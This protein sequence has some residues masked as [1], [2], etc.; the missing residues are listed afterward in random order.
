MLKFQELA[1]FTVKIGGSEF[2]M[3]RRSTALMLQIGDVRKVFGLLSPGKGKENTAEQA[4]EA[5]IQYADIVSKTVQV[6]LVDIDGQPLD[7]MGLL[8]GELDHVGDPLFKAFMASGLDADP[9]DGSLK[10]QKEPS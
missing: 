4:A 3:R 7:G 9:I 2:K 5:A 6:A 8:A 1:F 10:G